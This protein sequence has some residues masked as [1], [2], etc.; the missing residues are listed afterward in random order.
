[1]NKVLNKIVWVIVVIPAIY[2]AIIW[3]KLPEKITTSFDLGGN[4]ERFGSKNDL[5]LIVGIL[6]AVNI[7]L[8]LLL[9]NAHRIDAKRNGKENKD[10]MGRMAFAISV[11]ISG[12]TCYLLY[13]STGSGTPFKARIIFGAIGLV[14]CIMGNYMHNIKPNYF[15]GYRTKWTLNNKENWRRTHLLAGKIW[16]AGGLFLAI[17]CLF[18]SE[19]GAPFFFLFITLTLTIIPGIFS[20]YLHKKQ[21]VHQ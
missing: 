7:A 18:S 12:I 13:N 9:A 10:R 16:F 3:S 14:W 2:L 4:A 15:A 17:I 5:P 21:N 20:Y 11:F 6:T 8:Y 1:M 19:K